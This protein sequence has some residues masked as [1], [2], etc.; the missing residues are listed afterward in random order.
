MT[1]NEIIKT[2]ILKVLVPYF[3]RVK[4]CNQK[5][6]VKEFNIES[7]L[8]IEELSNVITE[9]SNKLKVNKNEL[10][11]GASDDDYEHGLSAFL[12][13]KEDMSDSEYQEKLTKRVNI[14]TFPMMFKELVTN[15]GLTRYGSYSH[16]FKEFD[17]TS[18]FCMLKSEDYDRLVK[19]YSLSFK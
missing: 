6:V 10:K 9:L 4:V 13:V 17:D 19:Y 16:K 14:N 2:A 5:T 8:N 11:I 18:V 7:G 1:T 15:Q 12:E 3:K